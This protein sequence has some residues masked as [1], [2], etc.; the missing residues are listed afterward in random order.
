MLN[1]LWFLEVNLFS[2]ILKQCEVHNILLK[3]KK[4]NILFK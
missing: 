2:I 1:K 4:L 3:L